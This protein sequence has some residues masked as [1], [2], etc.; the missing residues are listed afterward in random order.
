MFLDIHAHMY[1]YPYPIS[2][3][4]DKD[5]FRMVFPN[6]E[7]LIKLH[8]EL[9]IDRAVIVPLV[10]PEV[11]VPQSVGEVIEFAN[12][13]GGRFIP[14]CSLDPRVLDNTNDSDLGFLIDFY[15]R[16][17][18]KGMGEVL[19]NM[20]FRDPKMQ[21]LFHH[22]EQAGFPLLFDCSGILGRDYG[23][24][25][26]PGLPQLRASL[27]KFPNLC[28]IGHGPAFWSE[29][30]TLP[31]G[32]DRC[33]YQETPIEKEGAVVKLMRDYP[34]LWVD[35]SARSGYSA[36]TRDIAFTRVFMNEFS[37]RIMF[38]TDICFAEKPKTILIDLL[39]EFHADGTLNDEKFEAITHRNAERLLNLND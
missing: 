16:Q 1:K 31:E 32:A 3:D 7:E 35:L 10:S 39:N 33:T 37:D 13:S 38:G 18:C 21:N 11:Y 15:K 6:G 8:D 5:K 25:D 2:Y 26:D 29:L 30:G 27:E 19:P 14:F 24:Y 17:G 9:G 23:L 4:K 36:M 20:E 28:F 22:C 12:N 34:N